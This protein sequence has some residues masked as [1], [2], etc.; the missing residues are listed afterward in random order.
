VEDNMRVTS[1]VLA[2]AA[3][4]LACAPLRAQTAAPDAPAMAEEAA[5]SSAP[6]DP[7]PPPSVTEDAAPPPPAAA[8]PPVA[9][10]AVPQ[11]AAGRFIFSRVDGGILRLDSVSGQV[12]LCSQ[13]SAGWACQAVPEER[14]AF[15]S[16]VARLKAEVDSLKAEIAVLR[17]PAQPPR[18]P[19]EL[20]PHANE[21]KSG[22]LKLPTEEDIKWAR[23]QIERVW[24]Q[25]VDMV[26]DFQKDVERKG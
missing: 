9:Q 10:Q 13:R 8:A 16:E 25:F 12:T 24:R 7:A 14:A 18:P 26:T 19:A 6:Q 11:P 1:L 23:A 3:A 21:N 20:S 5:P 17:A 15:D 22:V 4:L 2:A